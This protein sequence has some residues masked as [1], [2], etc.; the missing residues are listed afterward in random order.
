MGF[1]YRAGRLLS[2]VPGRDN[3]T[4]E[5]VSARAGITSV[6]LGQPHQTAQAIQRSVTST[7]EV[8]FDRERSNLVV[9]HHLTTRSSRSF[10]DWAELKV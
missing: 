7:V 6:T 5:P 10:L 9:S 8:D 2:S 3:H 4:C 1:Q